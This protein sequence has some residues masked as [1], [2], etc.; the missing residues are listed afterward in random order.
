MRC[1]ILCAAVFF[2]GSISHAADWEIDEPGVP[3]Q[4]DEFDA[5]DPVPANGEWNNHGSSVVKIRA[6]QEQGEDNWSNPTSIVIGSGGPET[7]STT[8]QT[9]EYTFTSLAPGKWRV[10]I[11]DAANNVKETSGEFD[12]NM[13]IPP[14]P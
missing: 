7:G 2:G 11:A 8:G 1:F 10:Q 5:G 6:Q 4:S 13:P 9:W 14:G 12:V 3:D